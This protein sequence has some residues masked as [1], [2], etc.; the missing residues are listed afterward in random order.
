[1]QLRRAAVPLLVLLLAATAAPAAAA[2]RTQRRAPSTVS[3]TG[4]GWGHGVGLSQYGARNRAT[5]GQGWRAIVQHYYPGTRWGTAGGSVRIRLDADTS[6]DVLVLPTTGLKVQR[7][8]AAKKWKLPARIHG[9]KVVRWRIVPKGTRSVVQSKVRTWRSWRVVKGS[10]QF[11]AGGRPMTLVTPHGR[12][13]Y[14]GVLRSVAHRTVNVVPFETYLRGVVP[15]E[16]PASWPAN[17]VRAQ[18]VAA[19]TYAAF[20]RRDHRGSYYDLCD[21]ASCQVY[22]GYGAENARSNAAVKATAHT[23]VTYGGRPAFTQF[24]ASN[25]GYS[26]AGSF[27]YLRAAADPYDRGVPGDPW[28]KRFGAAAITRNWQ[29][30]GNLVSIKVVDRDGTSAHPGHVRTVRVQGSN[31]TRVVSAA[32]L[33]SWLGLRSTMFRITTS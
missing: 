13:A 8:G 31:F 22:G 2:E 24:S 21:T 32:T 16:V 5:A 14:R 15:R 4:T 25:G 1:M 27:P 17:A 20:E 26:V 10:A 30:M 6:K 33:G 3:F 9:R 29:G 11:T 12:A 7:V 18:S 23:I 19:R 28:R